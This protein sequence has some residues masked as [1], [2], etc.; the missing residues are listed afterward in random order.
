M[1]IGAINDGSS[2]QSCGPDVFK[3]LEIHRLLVISVAGC[4][5]R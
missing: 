4:L 2:F 1:L 3:V 5:H